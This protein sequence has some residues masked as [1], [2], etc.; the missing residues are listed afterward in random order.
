M[1]LTAVFPLYKNFDTL[2]VMGPLQAFLYGGIDSTLAAQEPGGVTSLEGITVQATE[3]FDCAPQYDILFVPGGSDIPSVLDLGPRGSNPYLDFLTRQA[4]GAKLVCSVCTGSLLLGAARLLDN[5]T[6]T[7]HWAYM[8][9]LRLFPCNVVEDYR[10]YVHSGNVVTGG[11]ISSGIDEA[12]YIISVTAGLDAARRAQLSMQ[13]HPQPIVHCGDPGQADIRDV[14]EL[15][16]TIQSDW[17]VAST[18][19]R[20]EEWLSAKSMAVS[21]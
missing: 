19:L 14:P 15:P 7:T 16:A 6:V 11:G 1:S 21:S 18:L 13:Y 8:D 20:V 12:I 10:R 3:S 9:V 2:D 17:G 4:Q 5:R